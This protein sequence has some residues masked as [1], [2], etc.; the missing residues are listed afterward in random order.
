VQSKIKRIGAVKLAM[1]SV[2]ENPRMIE[3]AQEKTYLELRDNISVWRLESCE[4]M[5]AAAAMVVV[6]G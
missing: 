2:L 5:A 3:K 6:T 4:I 1:K